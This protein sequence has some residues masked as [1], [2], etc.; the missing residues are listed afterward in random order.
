MDHPEDAFGSLGQLLHKNFHLG[1]SKLKVSACLVSFLG[2]GSPS[3][4]PGCTPD[5]LSP[6]QKPSRD[7]TIR[8]T[9]LVEELNRLEARR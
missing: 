6:P 3:A 1:D 5:P 9:A 2:M 8:M 4:P 7:T